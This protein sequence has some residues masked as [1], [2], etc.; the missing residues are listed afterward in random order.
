M[1]CEVWLEK[2]DAY[3][4]G[5]LASAEASALSAH[6][7]ICSA[8]AAEALERVLL[9]RSVAGAGKRYDASA[10]FRARIVKN[11]STKPRQATRS[12]GW[13]W[14]ILVVPA[15]LVVILSIGV[16]LFVKRESARRLRVYGELADLHVAALAS[17]NPV[18]VVST[19]RH[20][21]K[22]WFEGKIPFTFNLPELQGT[23][24]TL[25]GGRVTY[26]A[27]TPGAELIYRI[28]KHEI[29]VFIFQDHQ[30]MGSA[31]PA[32]DHAFSFT[33]ESWTQNGLRY[34]IVGDV[35]S[36]DL[37]AL[38]KLFRDAG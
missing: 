27:Q 11:I 8:C 32:P 28:R 19:D 13:A 1:A 17:A 20:T 30:E 7:R 22:P 6:L 16:D 26:L 38:S 33:M 36:G 18:D 35:S 5:E 23:D 2:L 10:E 12:S 21:V 4:D 29:S 31:S 9:K 24:F 34:F 15:L 3:L 25:V 37:Q 14:R